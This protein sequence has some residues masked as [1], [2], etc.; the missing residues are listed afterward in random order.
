MSDASSNGSDSE[1]DGSAI[2]FERLTRR[3]VSVPKEE[4]D[5]QREKAMRVVAKKRSPRV[6]DL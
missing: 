4:I 2:S 6:S 1:S 3:V 5:K